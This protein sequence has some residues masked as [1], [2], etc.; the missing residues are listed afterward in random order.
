MTSSSPS[1]SFISA[2]S[3]IMPEIL[4][5]I[6]PEMIMNGGDR[7]NSHFH[8][9]SITR[10]NGILL[11][12]PSILDAGATVEALSLSSPK[13]SMSPEGT[14]EATM[15]GAGIMDKEAVV[16]PDVNGATPPGITEKAI[17][18]VEKDLLAKLQELRKE[19]SRLFSLFRA[20]VNREQDVTLQSPEPQP[21]TASSITEASELGTSEIMRDGR[22]TTST[23][24]E[25]LQTLREAQSRE[26][27]GASLTE[28]DEEEE[29][30]EAKKQS[31]TRRSSDQEHDKRTEPLKPTGKRY[32]LVTKETSFLL[33][34]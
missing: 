6:L 20:A 8:H 9:E 1:G 10:S 11:A 12:P 33:V 23:S 5:E 7:R 31:S 15:A 28:R 2:I 21:P 34:N 27:N 29:E 3:E 24:G 17:D 19:K 30:E 4:P 25:A 18:H 14:P 13:P 16:L 26:M 32:V 22:P